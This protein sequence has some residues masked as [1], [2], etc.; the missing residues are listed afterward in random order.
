M[1]I[2]TLFGL[3]TR[4]EF[5]RANEE[6]ALHVDGSYAAPFVA[7]GAAVLKNDMCWSLRHVFGLVN[8]SRAVDVDI[9]CC[10]G[11]DQRIMPESRR[12]AGLSHFVGGSL[13]GCGIEIR[14]EVEP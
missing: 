7:V 10:G 14:I 1:K 6:I 12:Q 13:Q 4:G 11:P 2:S 3:P 8:D 5:H 9:H